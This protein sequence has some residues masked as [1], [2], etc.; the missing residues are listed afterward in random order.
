M[1]T[2]ALQGVKRGIG[3]FPSGIWLMTVLDL[4]MTL[5]WSCAAPFLAIYLHDERGLSMSVVGALFLAG[6]LCTGAANLVG[7]MLTDR[8]GRRRLLIVTSGLST[9]ASAA[10]AMLAGTSAA[11]WLI[12]LTFIVSRSIGGL[13]GPALG[14]IIADLSP[15]D[16]L[17]ESYAVVRTGGNLGFAIGPALGGFLIGHWSY[18]WVFGI[19]AIVGAAVTLVV[20]FFLAESFGR[21]KLGVDLRSTF[22]VAGDTRFL[23]FAIA[24]VLLV[25]SIGHM[26]STMSVFTTDKLGFSTVQYGLLLATNGIFVMVFQYPVTRLVQNLARSRGMILGTL[27]YVAGYLSLGWFSSFG[28]AMLT[29]CL[30]S[31]GEVVGSPIA[32]AV[33]AEAAPADK[34]GRYMGFYSLTQTLGLA[35]SPL[36]GGALLDVFPTEPRLLWGTIA[37]MGV[38][39]AVSFY[40]WGKMA[41]KRNEYPSQG[42]RA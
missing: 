7:G 30:I 19:A 42:E 4:L 37:S 27:F 20:H 34:R 35:L 22:A 2:I 17:A 5:G 14:A 26:G 9:L 39:A 32:S 3:R 11:I 13:G 31:A 1:K 33:V 36:F 29:I 41:G 8:F 40:V 24:S 23:V 38:M 25:L 28:L 15:K 21:G 12:V 10:M 6:G 16:R 18:G